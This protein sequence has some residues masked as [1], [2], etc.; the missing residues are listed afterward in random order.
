MERRAGRAVFDPFLRGWF[1]QHAFQSVTTDQFVDYLRKN[2]LA[3]HPDVMPEA[4]LNDWLYGTG[5]PASAQH[6]VSPR[7]TL[8]DQHRDAWLKGELPTK[9]LGMDKWVALESMHF[10]NDINGKASA[11]QMRE[12]DQ[13]YGVGKSGNNEVAYRFYLASVNA[14][15]DVH[16]P[17]QAFLLS[18]GRQKFV[19]PLYSAL[20]KTPQGHEWAKQVYA[21]ARERYHPVTQESV[22]KLMAAQAH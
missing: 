5:I 11:A 3:Q 6:V 8:L 10:L 21:K 14:G 22:D 18:V 7:L 15:Y 2:L 17:L 1:D 20:M 12:L 4:E 9:E 16:Q 19:V 13:V